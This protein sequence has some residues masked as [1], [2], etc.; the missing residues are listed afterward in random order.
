MH[1][2][3]S[4]GTRLGKANTHT[5]FCFTQLTRL[6]SPIGART[7]DW[8]NDVTHTPDILDVNSILFVCVWVCGGLGGGVGEWGNWN[9]HHTPKHKVPNSCWK[10]GSMNTQIAMTH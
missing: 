7:V 3:G 5:Y 8:K 1:M 6:I 10:H 4:L 2:E 9:Q